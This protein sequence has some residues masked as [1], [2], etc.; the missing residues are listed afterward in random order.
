MTE[1]FTISPIIFKEEF[2]RWLIDHIGK[3]INSQRL[4]SANKVKIEDVENVDEKLQSIILDCHDQVRDSAIYK[5]FK[6]QGNRVYL[7][8]DFKI[9]GDFYDVRVYQNGKITIMN[10]GSRSQNENLKKIIRFVYLE[11]KYLY[12][13]WGQN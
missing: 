13:L 9:L 8:C 4:K 12:R 10:P 11:M 7:Q 6:D 5:N 2:F 1:V 3:D